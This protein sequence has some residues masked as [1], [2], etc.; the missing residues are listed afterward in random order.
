VPI[1]RDA[2]LKTAE[3][4]LRQGK[5]DGAIEQYVRLVDEHPRDWSSINALGDLYVRAGDLD[6]AVAQYV[7]IADDL[8]ADGSVPKATALYRKALK[9]RSDHEHTLVRLSEIAARQGLLADAKLY[10]R[11]LEQ[12]RKKRG[13]EQGVA[14][15]I[16]RLATIDEHDGDAKITAANLA[17]RMGDIAQAVTL[18]QDAAAI[19][20]TEKRAADA[21]DA[22]IAVARLSPEDTRLRDAV[23]RALIAAGQIER[24]QPFLSADNVGNNVDLLLAVGRNALHA[25]RNAEAHATLM[26]AV[27]LAPDRQGAVAGLSDELLSA[28]RVADAYAC[29]EILVDAALFEAAFG[30]AAQLLEAFV[31]RHSLVPALLKLVDVYVD[32]GFDDR[33][34]AVQAKLADAYLEAGQAAE[35]RVIAEDLLSREPTVELHVLRLHRVLAALGVDDPDAVVARLRETA[36]LF[37]DLFELS[38]S[39]QPPAADRSTSGFPS[40]EVRVSVF[41]MAVPGETDPSPGLPPPSVSEHSEI[42]LSSVLA[43]LHI[44]PGVVESREQAPPTDDGRGIWDD[45]RSRSAGLDD[46]GA[47]A[48]AR[49]ERAQER[50]RTGHVADAS[51]DLQAAA[52][53]PALQFR[54]AAQLGRLLLS[55]DD[56]TGAVEWLGWAVAGPVPPGDELHGV[57]YDLAD[58]LDRAG[59]SV[60]A[61]TLFMEL[62]ADTGGYR[63]VRT[64]IEQMRRV[65]ADAPRSLNRERR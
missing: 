15:C 4:L 48:H 53:E 64:R 59:E 46:R 33:M 2:A 63:D 49:F 51:A 9:V 11:Q 44:P 14:E 12:H 54:A 47:E 58:A 25:G 7:R 1:D 42:D 17:E 40:D 27:A 57:L 35:A 37:E 10:L 30:R 5:L 41:G 6:R 22:H 52:R 61:L 29:V 3:R 36:P 28:G 20:E 21:L 26:R 38:E 50:L 8:L 34:S 32:A 39:Y 55:R 24:A 56:L 18:F 43:E 23:A 60:R 31:D 16:I 19:Y 65:T 62:D 13:D 45:R